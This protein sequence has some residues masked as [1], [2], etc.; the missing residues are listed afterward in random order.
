MLL[1]PPIDWPWG[2]YCLYITYSPF[3]DPDG[4]ADPYAL[5]LG[6]F[7][8]HSEGE[9]AAAGLSML[10]IMNRNRQA[11]IDELERLLGTVD[12]PTQSE[13]ESEIRT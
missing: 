3:A 6:E 10:S 11:E 9:V 8:P 2:G 1:A 5:L 12:L 13:R 7:G 4:L